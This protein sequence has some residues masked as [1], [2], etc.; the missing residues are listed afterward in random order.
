MKSTSFTLLSSSLLILFNMT[1]QTVL[2]DGRPYTVKE[3]HKVDSDTYL[4]YKLYRNWCA[5]CHGTFAQGLAAPSLTSSLKSLDRSS[6]IRIVSRGKKGKMGVM[7]AWQSNQEVM[8]GI[9]Q[10]YSYLRARTDGAL[11]NVVPELNK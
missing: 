6:F 5:R 10:I 9:D 3:G 4:G 7:P 1:W 11:G 8:K 2:A